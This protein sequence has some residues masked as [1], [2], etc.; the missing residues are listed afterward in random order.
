MPR[1][2]PRFEYLIICDDIRAEIKN[3]FTLVGIYT[4]SIIL[5]KLPYS[6]PKLCFFAQYSNIR[7]GDR[8]SVELIDPAGKK[9]GK[10]IN[11]IIQPPPDKAIKKLRLLGIYSPLKIEQ[12]G[13]Y[14][15]IITFEEDEK[16]KKEI[17]FNINLVTKKE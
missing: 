14:S 16:N 10:P 11:G 15:L 8:F 7:A 12:E 3:K 2:K 4:D 6:F 5:S 17:G 9:L 13:T 1:K